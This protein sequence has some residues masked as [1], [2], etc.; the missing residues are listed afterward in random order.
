V[1]QARA[2]RDNC[3]EMI[4]QVI[5]GT[6]GLDDAYSEAQRR[7]A[8]QQTNESRFRFPGPTSEKTAGEGRVVL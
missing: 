2:V 7:K 6:M 1:Q 8:A 5:D 3:P 4:P